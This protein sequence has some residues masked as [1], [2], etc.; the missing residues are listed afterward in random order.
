M[1]A[2]WVGLGWRSSIVLASVPPSR[3]RPPDMTIH[4]LHP[5]GLTFQIEQGPP[6]NLQ[7]SHQDF[8]LES[9]QKLVSRGLFLT[10]PGR[11]PFLLRH[12]WAGVE[13]GNGPAIGKAGWEHCHKIAWALLLCPDTPGQPGVQKQGS[14]HNTFPLRDT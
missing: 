2:R 5:D 4:D 10:G 13:P 12:I 7:L 1:R 6:N 11:P 9:Y 14:H 3:G 8:P